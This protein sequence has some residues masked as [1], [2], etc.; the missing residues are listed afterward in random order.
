MRIDPEKLEATIREVVAAMI[1]EKPT[2]GATPPAAET[3]TALG[4]GVFPDMDSAITA[5][6][7]A[8]R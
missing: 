6:H 3:E 8:Q 7:R 1:Q 5:A 2:Q 4:D